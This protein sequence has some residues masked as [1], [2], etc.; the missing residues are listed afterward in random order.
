MWFGRACFPKARSTGARCSCSTNM[1]L[2]SLVLRHVMRNPVDRFHENFR[3]GQLDIV[4][5]SLLPRP[6]AIVCVNPNH[7]CTFSTSPPRLQQVPTP[8]AALPRSHSPLHKTAFQ[9]PLTFAIRTPFRR[10]SRTLP[11]QRLP[12]PLQHHH[13]QAKSSV[14]PNPRYP[15]PSESSLT[16]LIHLHQKH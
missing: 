9:S 10:E 8:P 5:D 15:Q 16:R 11:P 2:S 4:R 1:I 3:L 7:L 12:P 14:Q 13:A 6:P